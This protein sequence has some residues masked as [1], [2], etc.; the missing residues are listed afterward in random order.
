MRVH[1]AHDA[2]AA[3]LS[4]NLAMVAFSA[5]ILFAVLVIVPKGAAL[6]PE[7]DDADRVFLL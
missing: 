6:F 7:V 3:R 1:S 2:T 4:L 5:M